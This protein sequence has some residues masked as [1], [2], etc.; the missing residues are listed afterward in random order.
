[1]QAARLDMASAVATDLVALVKRYQVYSNGFASF[2]GGCCGQPYLEHGGVITMALNE[3]LVQDYDGLLRI[4][5]AWPSSWNGSGTVSIQNNS[6]VD[7]QYESGALI[8][9]V[10]EAGATASQNVR[11]PWPGQTVQVVDATMG[12]TVSSTTAATFTIS[13]VSGHKYLIERAS[14]PFTSLTYAQVTGTPATH[15]KHLG[16]AQLGSDPGLSSFYNN[17]GL[18]LDSNTNVGNLDGGGLSFS[19]TAITA[20]GAYPGATGAAFGGVTMT[21]PISA[22]TG[23]PDNVLAAG[24][25]VALSGSSSTLGFIVA[26][27]Y[28]TATGTGT[29]TYTDGST[30]TFSITAPDWWG[31]PPTGSSV[32]IS[33]SY[34][35][36]PGNVQGSQTV[37]TYFVSVAINP[38]KSLLSV[39]L[40]NIGATLAPGVTAMHIFCMG[41]Q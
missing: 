30:Q 16:A 2:N 37:Y 20:F 4:A 3:A 11:S 25:T 15:A 7:V 39:Q 22:G 40:P 10:L 26:G 17:V 29:I 32:A 19:Q 18:T 36:A 14:A 38:S 6:K 9:V 5:P 12:T 1:M 28:G 31:P 24:Q 34:L 35:N 13:M 8:T 41:I 23:S 21:W 33:A 27:S